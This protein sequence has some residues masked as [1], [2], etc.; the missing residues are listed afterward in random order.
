MPE[1]A[2]P[3]ERLNI[4]GSEETPSLRQPPPALPTVSKKRISKTGWTIL[5]IVCGL[6]LLGL[7]ACTTCFV[8]LALIGAEQEHSAKVN[9]PRLDAA[10]EAKMAARDWAGAFKDFDEAVDEAAHTS[11][12]NLKARAYM[13]RASAEAMLGDQAKASE[14]FVEGYEAEPR[15]LVKT[16]GQR[17]IASAAIQALDTLKTQEI[18]RANQH[19]QYEREQLHKAY[20]EFNRVGDEL[21]I[22]R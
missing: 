10:G 4:A 17:E 6:P 9:L 18:E 22:P 21:G 3:P 13:G 19:R 11:D 15:F 8:G 5:I 20:E 12:R 7:G 14:D 2:P 16:F 1:S